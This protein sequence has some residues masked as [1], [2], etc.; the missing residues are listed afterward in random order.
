VSSSTST[1]AVS[2]SLPRSFVRL[3]AGE[4]VAMVGNL[5]DPTLF[6]GRPIPG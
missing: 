5:L 1:P 2:S 3:G 4:K 6:V